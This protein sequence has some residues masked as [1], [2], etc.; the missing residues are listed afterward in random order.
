MKNTAF[1]LIVFSVLSLTVVDYGLTSNALA[2]GRYGE[3]NG[4]VRWYVEKP[5][6]AI[7]IISITNYGGAYALTGL[8]K[9][10]K[11]LAWILA[12]GL[13]ILKGYIVYH[14]IKVLSK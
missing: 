1:M 9:D 8:F 13:F 10:N 5:A 6:L 2:T 4:L 12:G 14:N 11:T 7:P 3:A